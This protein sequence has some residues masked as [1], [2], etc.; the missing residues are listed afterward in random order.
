[1]AAISFMIGSAGVE[2]TIQV[3]K[4]PKLTEGV[5]KDPESGTP[6][7]ESPV[8]G[9]VPYAGVY[10]VEL[11]NPVEFDADDNMAIVISFPE[12]AAFMYCDS[13]YTASSSSEG[14][15]NAKNTVEAG[16]SLYMLSS[17][18]QDMSA[19]GRSLRIN[20]LT[21]DDKTIVKVPTLQVMET[22]EA[23]G[24]GDMPYVLLRWSKCSAVQGY[25]VYRSFDG[26]NYEKIASVG[27][28][29]RQYYDTLPAREETKCYYQ[30]KA[31][32]NNSTGESSDTVEES[33]IVNTQ[34]TGV[35]QGAELAITYNGKIA[36]FSWKAVEGADLYE[37]QRMEDASG[38][39]ETVLIF[40]GEQ[41]TYSF[42]VTEYAMGIYSYRIRAG[43][44]SDNGTMY[45]QWSEADL[46]KDFVV[47]SSG[48]QTATLSW[49]PI[50]DAD[51]YKVRIL[52]GTTWYIYSVKTSPENEKTS[53][54]FQFDKVSYEVKTGEPYQYR[55]MAYQAGKEIY[56]SSTIV[57]CLPP[58]TPQLYVDTDNANQ[59]GITLAWSGGDGATA[60]DIYRSESAQD[61]GE[62]I[63]T[64]DIAEG[65]YTDTTELA[66][67]KMYFYYLT[68]YVENTMGEKIYGLSSDRVTVYQPPAVPKL[69]SVIEQ[70]GAV[71]IQWGVVSSADGYVLEK[72]E[73]GD[74]FTQIA[75]LQKEIVQEKESSKN[76]TYQAENRELE[77]DDI[78][79]YIDKDVSRCNQYRY[80]VT[81]YYFNDAGESIQGST[82]EIGTIRLLPEAAEIEKIEELDAGR[83]GMRIAVY[84]PQIENAQYF[85]LYRSETGEDGSYRQIAKI[86]DSSVYIDQDVA[87]ETAYFYK[88]LV[89]IDA[90]TSALKDTN[91]VQI[92]T[93][94]KYPEP[95]TILSAAEPEGAAAGTQVV[96]TI[97]QVENAQY[98]LLY[99]SKNGENGAYVQIAKILADGNAKNAE[100]EDGGDTADTVTYIDNTVEPDTEYYYK[101]L[102]AVNNVTSLMQETMTFSIRTK[103]KPSEEQP[104]DPDNPNP[105]DANIGNPN[106]DDKELEKPI[107]PE[108]ITIFSIKEVDSG[109]NGAQIV[110][111]IA[112]VE[113]AQYYYIYRSEDGEHGTYKQIAALSAMQ[114]LPLTEQNNKSLLEV[115]ERSTEKINYKISDTAGNFITYT[116]KSIKPETEYFY[117]VLVMV[118]NQTTVLEDTNASHIVTKPILQSFTMLLSDKDICQGSS[119]ELAF[120]VEPIYYPYTPDE[121][122]WA[123]QDINGKALSIVASDGKMVVMGT[124]EKELLSIETIT[125]KNDATKNAAMESDSM[126]NDSKEYNSIAVCKIYAIGASE[127]KMVRLFATLNGRS[128][129]VTICIYKNEGFQVTSV[130]NQY[131]TGSPITPPIKVY[132]QGR[133][134]TKGVDYSVSYKNNKN[135][136][137]T[138]D[139]SKAPSV[140]VTGKGN[141]TGKETLT[142]SILPID[143]SDT[144]KDLAWDVG[145]EIAN[146]A[147]TGTNTN[148][149]I[150]PE[151]DSYGMITVDN[152]I[153]AY[154]K[155][156]IQKPIPTVLW[157]GSPLKKGRD[158]TVEYPDT[159]VGAYRETGAYTVRIKGINNFTGTRDITL[160]ITN[161]GLISKTTVSKIKAQT[162]TG[163]EIQPSITVK[164]GKRILIENQDYTVTY[165]NNVEVGTAT[166]IITGTGLIGDNNITITDSTSNQSNVSPSDTISY[167]GVK[168]VSFQIKG[169][170]INKAVVSGL[171]KSVV[172]TGSPIKQTNYVLSMKTPQGTETLR[173]GTDYIT[174]QNSIN[175]GTGYIIFQGINAYTGTLK[176]SFK[177]TPYDLEADIMQQMYFMMDCNVPYTKGGSMPAVEVMF[178]YVSSQNQKELQSDTPKNPQ[179]RQPI[180]L[181]NGVDYKLTYRNHTTISQ[182]NTPSVTITGKGNFKG[183]KTLEFM[184]LKQDIDRLSITASD[185]VYTAKAG[186]YKTKVS[187]TDTNGKVL[188]AGKDYESKILYTYARSVKLSDGTIR[189][190]G[191]A[192][193]DKDILPIGTLLN[194]TVTGINNYQGSL[195]GQFRI[196]EFD[197]SKA[198]VTIT[199]QTYTGAEIVPKIEDITVVYKG[200]V[201]EYGTEY[202]IE[203][204]A[205]NI[206]KGKAVMIIQGIGDFGGQKKVKFV[207]RSK[208]VGG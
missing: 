38:T 192:V 26:Q 175:A 170:N 100:S 147:T 195:T 78:C 103:A 197:V 144:E 114:E 204:C 200:R 113:S 169:I 45:S 13:D 99:R 15:C 132:D 193:G 120:L 199:P 94:P 198:K 36:D 106:P 86:T 75:D 82:S 96:L 172:Y 181:Q 17:T 112:K 161:E 80:R 135:V 129:A 162:Y 60:V 87:Y 109:K 90:F 40:Q 51:E 168:R 143:I 35:I 138:S 157:N 125:A 171:E 67:K 160:L 59:Q 206:K 42:D 37:L 104:S 53:Y 33:N 6:M 95:I 126:E 28:D 84:L 34:F 194:A 8:T 50:A 58:A 102:V 5:V 64:L 159:S 56:A 130:E 189:S 164:S 131:Y 73:N 115:E 146:T 151:A 74:I 149:R 150:C 111:T 119:Q 167:Y 98:Y 116:D 47:E 107:L 174:I 91:A 12:N 85:Q 30:V 188:K 127:V 1:M 123:A 69:S 191:E 10:T 61:K 77:N 41:T 32:Y 19:S 179:I 207:I 141:Y 22:Q 57:H 76:V 4:N 52:I 11:P 108:P 158:F 165:V 14:S 9:T 184:I 176:K 20:A 145:K 101:V 16:E 31:L 182:R 177:I 190:E 185:K 201:L 21:I 163:G 44:E 79:Q 156:K 124:D 55:M 152:V 140:I 121:L 142:F 183:K 88:V 133:L 178:G 65:S 68:P 173:E 203:D 155:N 71:V 97:P 187:V 63:A 128:A 46:A 154:R 202:I 62:Q 49:L 139:I 134:L 122:V 208:K 70:D 148:G 105:D 25:E 137:N 180:F 7:L 2:Y 153:C 48:Y 18:W 186:A 89:T 29:T 54:T 196:T 93:K 92:V 118:Q 81:A 166:A 110:L 3:Y 205:D 23:A 27:A 24:F 83:T 72:S 136:N 43:K 66:I 117:K 39:Y